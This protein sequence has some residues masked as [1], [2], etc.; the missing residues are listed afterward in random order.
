M[1][2]D[3]WGGDYNRPLSLNQWNYTEGNPVNLVDPTGHYVDCPPGYI[4]GNSRCVRVP[5]IVSRRQ[6]GAKPIQDVIVFCS[7]GFCSTFGEGLYDAECNPIGYALYSE[8]YPD[9]TLSAYDTIVVHHLGNQNDATIQ[10][11]QEGHLEEGYAD[12]AYHYVIA[13]DGAIYEGR[14]IGVRGAH[15]TSRNSWKIGILVV[16]DFEPG[17]WANVGSVEVKIGNEPASNPTEAQKNSLMELSSYLDALYGIDFILGHRE[18]PGQ[19]T[20]CPGENLMPFVRYLR[21]HYRD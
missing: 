4:S 18:V 8:L 11:I 12:I 1:S 6:W 5:N 10:E 2:R 21:Q 7:H 9:R 17:E 19:G 16:G 14:D 13:K 15:V 20:R 3:T